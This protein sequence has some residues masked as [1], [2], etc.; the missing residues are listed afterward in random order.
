M[1]NKVHSGLGPCVLIFV[2]FP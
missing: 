2:W 1:K